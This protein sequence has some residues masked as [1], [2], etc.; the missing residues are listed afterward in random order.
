MSCRIAIDAM[1]G[2]DAPAV[3]VE[4][5]WLAHEDG[6]PVV[7][8]GDQ[9]RL[10]SLLAGRALPIVHAP[11]AL[12]MDAG[13]AEVRRSPDTS[14]RR[15]MALV[16][17]GEA[18]AVVSCGGSGATLVAAVM[19]VGLLDGVERPAITVALPRA[20]GGTLYL[21]DAGATVDCRPDHLVC[22]AALGAA[23]AR[24][25]G[26]EDARVGLLSNGTEPHKGTRV[27]RE[28]HALLSAAALRYVGQVEPIGAFAGEVDVLV[29]DGFAG[30]VLL[31][32]AEGLIV[33]LR[34]LLRRELDPDLAPRVARS[35]Q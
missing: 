26:V 2:D 5:A 8:V 21:L 12:A 34:E 30:N 11:D 31:K 22:F 6:V 16:R 29:A 9:P 18:G 33:L 25:M 32:T 13:A 35:L 19:D 14:I 28:A 10:E 7:L 1:G 15:A 3:V 24:A 4:G 27:V 17:D 20:D 23:W